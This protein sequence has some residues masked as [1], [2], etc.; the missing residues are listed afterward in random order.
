M[1]F[2]ENEHPI[3][4]QGI[5]LSTNEKIEIVDIL[6]QEEIMRKTQKCPLSIDI[7]IKLS[8]LGNPTHKFPA[9]NFLYLSTRI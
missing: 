6:N 3:R 4:S 8:G 2:V 5:L 7:K 9:K 1:S